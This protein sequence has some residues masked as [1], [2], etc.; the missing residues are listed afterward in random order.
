MNKGKQTHFAFTTLINISCKYLIGFDTK[1]LQRCAKEEEKKTRKRK[2]SQDEKEIGVYKIDEDST[3][4]M[5]C[6]YMICKFD[7]FMYVY[8][9]NWDY[10][11][12]VCVCVCRFFVAFSLSLCVCVYF[13]SHGIFHTNIIIYKIGDVWFCCAIFIAFQRKLGYS[14]PFSFLFFYTIFRY[15]LCM[16]FSLAL[17]GYNLFL[18]SHPNI[19]WKTIEIYT[20]CGSDSYSA[21]G[22]S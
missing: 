17:F 5:Y 15:M 22:I 12:C 21:A 7:V 16:L 1:V 19:G 11:S 20:G 3:L 14:H 2:Y 18:F 6:T 9:L 4:C 8:V 13:N 10:T